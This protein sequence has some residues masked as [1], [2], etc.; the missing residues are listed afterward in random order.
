MTND[1]LSRDDFRASD[2]AVNDYRYNLMPGSFDAV[3]ILK[4]QASKG[5]LRVFF[6]FDD[7]RHVIAPVYGWQSYLG[8]YEIPIGSRVR[9]TYTETL[10]GTFLTGV[11]AL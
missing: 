1:V 7:G 4:A 10:R 5:I 2:M 11:E 8:F 6:L 3:V 9:L